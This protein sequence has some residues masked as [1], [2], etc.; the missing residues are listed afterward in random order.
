[1][2]FCVYMRSDSTKELTQNIWS[3]DLKND[4]LYAWL[5]T[6]NDMH[7]PL[8]CL[9][10]NGKKMAFMGMMD[11]VSLQYVRGTMEIEQNGGGVGVNA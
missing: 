8:K 6:G 3:F 10:R 4:R 9:T 11:N 5:I 1:M 7:S 2:C